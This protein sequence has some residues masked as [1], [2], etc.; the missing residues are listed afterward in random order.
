M[1]TLIHTDE[2]NKSNKSMNKFKWALETSF[3]ETWFPVP[4]HP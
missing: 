2:K 3:L 4:V 1:N